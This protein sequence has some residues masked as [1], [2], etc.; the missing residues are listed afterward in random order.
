MYASDLKHSSPALEEKLA[1]LYALNS[2]GPIALGFRKQY[3]DLLQALGN[4]HENL[5]PIIHI[6]GTNGK[7]SIVATLRAI[8]AEEGYKVHAYTSPH[9]CAF[10][11]RIVLA[12]KNITDDFLESLIDEALEKNAGGDV[13][14]FEITTAIAFA[15]FARTPA[16]ILLMEVGLGGRM[17][18]TNII[19]QPLVSIISSI[20]YDHMEFL[21]DTLPE[22]AAEK[23]G[24]IKPGV[25]VVISAQSKE[26]HEAGVV[27]LLSDMAREQGAPLSRQGA[28]W[29]TPDHG[30]VFKFV[31]KDV[32]ITLPH[33]NLQG[34]HQ[35]FNSGAAIAALKIIEDQFPVSEGSIKKGLKKIKWPGRLH[36][37][38]KH[39]TLPKNW[40]LWL[41]G[42]HNEDAAR[43]L[44]FQAVEW[45]DGDAKPL[46]MILG[47]MNRKDPVA[48]VRILQK[49]IESVTFV[50]IPGEPQSFKAKDMEL[51]AEKNLP[52]VTAYAAV[53][54][55]T[56]IRTLTA[57]NNVPGRI[58][59][60]GSLYL[61][62]HVLKS[63]NVQP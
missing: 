19:E 57:A 28:E 26:S 47:M 13:T 3:L 29:F 22:I 44:A 21:G 52:D 38:T 31:H 7:G 23:G 14:F 4:P 8:L 45:T 43:I 35:V 53:N 25:P 20:G 49:S 58:L 37:L 5:P 46:H 34:A 56:A 2:G 50:D 61:A 59:I 18:C 48:F 55:E 32:E 51:L 9:L 40:E 24:I 39:C 63:V 17:D 11:E 36:D 27:D 1:R 60:A 16:D 6:A 33:P 41:D 42:G 10:N 15:A 12:G 62:G 54:L 30:D